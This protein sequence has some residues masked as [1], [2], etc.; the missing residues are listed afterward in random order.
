MLTQIIFA[1]AILIVSYLL[2]NI[3]RFIT[4]K[5]FCA[6]CGALIISLAVFIMLDFPIEITSI[7]LG[8]LIAILSYYADDYLINKKKINLLTQDFLILLLLLIIGM[9]ILNFL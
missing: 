4:K 3:I 6:K 7:S 9:I 2:S 1:I 5:N 8:A